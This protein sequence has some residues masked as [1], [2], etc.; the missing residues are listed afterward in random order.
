MT[1]VINV[2]DAPAGWEHSPKYVYIGRKGLGFSGYFGNPYRP[3]EGDR[4][5]STLK[6]YK[7]Y[8]EER[9]R[10]DKEFYDRFVE[11]KDKTLVC[12]CKPKRCGDIM[13]EFL[14]KICR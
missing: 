3:K 5:G 12:F 4:H 10:T 2:K 6:K 8:L 11:L 1:K 9:L 7:V 13:V 14:D